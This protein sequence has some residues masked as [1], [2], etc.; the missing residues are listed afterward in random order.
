MVGNVNQKAAQRRREFISADTARSL[1]IG[2]RKA[3]D[4]GYTR[5]QSRGKFGKQLVSTSSGLQLRFQAR[6]LLLV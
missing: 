2:A 6:Q 1:E 4:A 5:C 3:A